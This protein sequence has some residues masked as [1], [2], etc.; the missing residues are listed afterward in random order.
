MQ[1]HPRDRNLLSLRYPGALGGTDPGE[2]ADHRRRRGAGQPHQRRRCGRELQ[3]SVPGIFAAGNVLHV[4]DLVDFVSLE[5]ERLAASVAVYLR[6]HQLPCCPIPVIPGDGIGHVIPQH[7]SGQRD[8]SLSLR[9]NR[10][11]ENAAIVVRQ[12]GRALCRKP[13]RK[14]A[15]AQMLELT[16]KAQQ[17]A[18]EQA[19]EVS[20]E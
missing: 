11:F 5:A 6:E 1:P 8:V 18:P 10:P 15:P 4:H 2:R 16:V 7:I 3:T 17:I 13:L 9:V 19:L 20:V 12:Q 14:I